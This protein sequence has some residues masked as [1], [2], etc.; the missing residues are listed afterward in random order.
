[1]KYEKKI[2]L[3]FVW[4]VFGLIL[5]LCHTFG[6]LKEDIYEGIGY[7]WLGCGIIQAVRQLRYRCDKKYR[8]D[9]D[10]AL[11]DERNRFISSKAWAWAGYGF[12]LIT[13]AAAIIC[14]AAG[15]P[16]TARIAVGGICLIISLYCI[17]Y[18]FLKIKY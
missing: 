1:M 15:Q 7:G 18:L 11:S 12:V 2:Y 5:V 9:C 10:I 13:A 14:S 8:E 17:A 16:D 6:V 4:I 3:S